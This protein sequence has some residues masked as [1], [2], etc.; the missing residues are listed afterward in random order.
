ME[1]NAIRELGRGMSGAERD[2][3]LVAAVGTPIPTFNCPT[4][5]EPLAYPMLTVN[6]SELAN[7]LQGCRAGCVLARSDYVVNAGSIN[8]IGT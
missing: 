6:F 8:A 2:I 5:R 4:R 1:N 3:A 7:N